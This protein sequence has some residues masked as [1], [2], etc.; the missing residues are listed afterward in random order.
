MD[1]VLIGVSSVAD[2]TMSA[3][4]TPEQQ[5]S[6]RSAYL[7]SLGLSAEQSI[8]VKLT[9]DSDDYKRYFSVATEHAGDGIA[10]GSSITSDALF[11]RSKNLALM[12]PIADCVG[13]VLY[14]AANQAFGLAH[15]GRHNL[16]QQGGTGIVEFMIDEFGTDPSNLAVWLSPAAGR[17]HYPLHDFDNR[18][19]HEVS[20]EQLAAA[21]V[22]ME[23]I[24][25]D[26]RDT[27]TDQSLFSHS[28]Y[29]KGNRAMD[30][31]QAVVAM[32]RF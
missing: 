1:N 14:D 19:L 13:A 7:R 10:F 9:Y 23:N 27:T 25:V 21:G 29:L 11:T 5:L 20:M 31:R 8:L 26:S 32:M 28:A 22:S 15:L 3:G 4:G 18:S 30:G 6:N 16:L 17:Q 24:Q 12:L 2:G